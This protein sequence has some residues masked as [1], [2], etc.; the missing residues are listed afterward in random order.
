MAR[1]CGRDVQL[2]IN[3]VASSRSSAPGPASSRCRSA[4]SSQPYEPVHVFRLLVHTRCAP[5]LGE[6]VVD[7]RE[8]A[9][10]R[11]AT[12]CEL[13]I[14]GPWAAELSGLTAA[15]ANQGHITAA[16][17]RPPAAPTAH[18]RAPRPANVGSKHSQLAVA[19]N[20]SRLGTVAA[21]RRDVGLLEA[22]IDNY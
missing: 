18:R 16:W 11:T 4:R 10:D 13:K 8:S 17:R 9:R 5:R 21:G 15:R 3:F 7:S 1:A 12:D 14:A 19:L 6:P 22:V 20:A 2:A